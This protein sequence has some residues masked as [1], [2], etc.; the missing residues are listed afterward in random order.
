[1]IQIGLTKDAYEYEIRGLLMAFYPGVLIQAEK[2]V[3]EKSWEE[4]AGIWEDKSE[5]NSR[6][7]ENK[8]ELRLGFFYP[9]E[10]GNG[11][12]VLWEKSGR[13]Q[14]A[15]FP[16][17]SLRDKETKTNLKNTLYA[18]LSRQT[19]K[20][21]PWGTLTGIRPT[22][23]PMAMLEEGKSDADI[24]YHMEKEL[25]CSREKSRLSLEIAKRER[26]ILKNIDYENGYSLYIGI[27]FCPTTCLYCSFTSYPI[28]SWEKRME[29]YIQALF[30]EIAYTAEYFSDKKLN[31]IY[32]GGG[33]PTTL[34]SEYL[35]RLLAKVEESLDLTYLQEY[36]V[37][38]GRPD[39]VTREKLEVLRRH[40]VTRISINPQT[41]KEETL[42][43]IGRR[44]T[45]QQVK[46]V[47]AMAREMGFDNINM[48]L[49]LGLPN[50]GIEDVRHTMEELKRLS[51]DNIT[52][53]SLAIKRAA[54][55]N[56]FRDQ[57]KELKLEN[58]EEMMD[59]TARYAKEMGLEPYYLYRQKNMA[60]NLENVGYALP[61]KAGIYN[62]LIMEEKQTIVAL[63]AGATTKAVW[64]GRIE[65]AENVKD[66][67]IYMEQVDEMIAR[68]KRLFGQG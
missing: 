35:D 58:S 50:E 36:T 51:P 29:D 68:K 65:R 33:T 47:Y 40:P 27:P 57:Y 38:A 24:L 39:S 13:R 16:F 23:I 3:E 49:I 5:E 18:L 30:R 46:D 59:L 37:E 2:E 56:M 34:S 28:I 14:E 31:T 67:G 1:M 62:I 55:L 41:M 4:T 17:H 44:H 22:K 12:I 21:L 61:G 25:L 45:V 63:G 53:H 19:G 43:I 42:K 26:E 9:E 10:E 60:G 52:V 20:T 48:D 32:F 66:V 8:T 54:R 11:R 15:D 7:E 6:Q 64:K